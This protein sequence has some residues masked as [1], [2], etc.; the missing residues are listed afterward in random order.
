[1]SVFEEHKDDILALALSATDTTGANDSFSSSSSSAGLLDFLNINPVVN[2]DVLAAHHPMPIAP[3]VGPT[4]TAA[5]IQPLPAMPPAVPQ[6]DDLMD[7]LG[8][9]DDKLDTISNNELDSLLEEASKIEVPKEVEMAF[10]SPSV[11]DSNRR[12]SFPQQQQEMMLPH[13]SSPLLPPAGNVVLTPLPNAN[14]PV[15]ARPIAS[16]TVTANTA[17]AP[18][19]NTVGTSNSIAPKC[20]NMTTPNKAVTITP[21]AA[22]AG[23]SKISVTEAFKVLGSSA[24]PLVN[25]KGGQGLINLLNTS[26]VKTTILN[27]STVPA[28]SSLSLS[29]TLSSLS[30]SFSVPAL[31]LGSAARV[32][33]TAATT[34]IDRRYGVVCVSVSVCLCVTLCFYLCFVCESVCV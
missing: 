24:K 20:I 5:P 2:K 14:T 6:E 31:S 32:T 28:S 8:L 12:F 4:F 1:M 17:F 22:T 3:V 11:A 26:I 16:N 10:N 21:N 29:S 19:P 9:S 7:M 18:A 15:T 34:T 13:V 33:S 23:A 30:S 25:I 27:T